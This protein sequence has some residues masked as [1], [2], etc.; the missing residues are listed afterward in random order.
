MA[1]YW[2]DRMDLPQ[3]QL[4]GQPLVEIYGYKRVLIEHH[5]GVTEYGQ[6]CVCVKVK[7]GAVFVEGRELVLS[8]MNRYTLVISGWI[9]G[10]RLQRRG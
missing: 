8:S 3:E 4:P 1:K 7:F 2:M 5:Q 9:D 6:N 10:I